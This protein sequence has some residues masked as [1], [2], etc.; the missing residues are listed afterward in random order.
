MAIADSQLPDVLR[1]GARYHLEDLRSSMGL[2]GT[3]AL[4]PVDSTSRSFFAD[5][6]SDRS[7]TVLS[8]SDASSE[9]HVAVEPIGE[10]DLRLDP[11]TGHTA[12]VGTFGARVHGTLRGHVGFSAQA[13][14]GSIAGNLDLARRDSLISHNGSFGVTGFGRDVSFSDGHLRVA[15]WGGS[16][17]IGHE[18]VA[19]GLG[20]TQSLLL[21]SDL[22]T[23]FDYLRLSAVFG[24]FSFTHLH[25]ALFG[26][27][28]TGPEHGPFADIRSK[29]LAVHLL[30]VGPVG[31]FRFSLGESVV[32]GGRGLELGYFNPFLVMK[33]Q[34][35]YLR[36]RDN[37]NM[38]FA[39][40]SSPVRGL[41][42][43]GEL[44]IDDLRFSK[45][46]KGYWGNKTAWRATARGIVPYVDQLRFDCSY[47]RREPYVL[48]HFNV[49][50]NYTHDG[51]SLS[52]G[53]IPPNSYLL[54]L[55]FEFRPTPRLTVA[56]RLGLGK[57]GAN[58]VVRDSVKGQDTLLFNAGGDILQTRR[59][60]IDSDTVEFL[61][62]DVERLSRGDVL[63]EYEPLRNVYLRMTGRRYETIGRG[64]T[65]TDMQLW[66]ALRIGA[67]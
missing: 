66:F 8:W 32:Y 67:H 55:G 47:T 27:L 2:I 64:S 53:G 15:A 30:S 11:T 10:L 4:I 40:S 22:P 16:L 3:L 12:A 17:E 63:I 43:E 42:L 51:V 5:P 31:G 37:G 52:G 39:M 41:T 28:S 60:G 18:R 45:I 44:L 14:N 33:T 19:L 25:A 65:D 48:T 26:A 6:L 57:H 7:L 59:A 38:Y 54:Q 29:Y 34:E 35:Q 24:S 9:T 50:N 62:G 36:D 61:D 56:A 49:E 1:R 46:G 20:G 21:T 58:V 23:R 13:T